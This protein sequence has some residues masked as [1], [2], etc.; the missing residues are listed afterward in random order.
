MA[1]PSI[2]SRNQPRRTAGPHH[3][4][5]RPRGKG[6][7]SG[8]KSA[9]AAS[10]SNANTSVANETIKDAAGATA[11]QTGAQEDTSQELDLCWICAEPVKYYA[12]SECNHRICH[13]C[14]LRLRALYKKLD[15]TFCK[16][17]RN[18]SR[19][20]FVTFSQRTQGTATDSHFHRIPSSPLLLLRIGKHPSQR[21]KAGNIVR[22]PGHDAEFLGFA[23][24]KLP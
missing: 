21:R 17:R 18:V 16:V 1:E 23:T 10:T 8:A 22:D 13:V 9:V 11:P 3:G 7:K 14:A 15:C 19:R 5:R 6:D 4:R 20:S 24:F 2:Q 12:V